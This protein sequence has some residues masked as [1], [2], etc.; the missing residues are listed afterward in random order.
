MRLEASCEMP[1]AVS[2]SLILT[3]PLDLERS[4]LIKGEY[5]PPGP[6]VGSGFVEEAVVCGLP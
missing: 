2:L 5:S 4:F 3:R 1:S 6:L